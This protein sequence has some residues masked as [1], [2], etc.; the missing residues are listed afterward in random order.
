MIQNL[1][2]TLRTQSRSESMII[3]LK[4]I[5]AFDTSSEES[6]RTIFEA[7]GVKLC[8]SVDTG[9]GVLVLCCCRDP[10]DCLSPVLVWSL[11]LLLSKVFWSGR[12]SDSFQ[13]QRRGSWIPGKER[14]EKVL[15]D[16]IS[17][18]GRKKWICKCCSE[19]NVWTRWRC[20]RC[21]TN[22]P[23]GLRVTYQQAVAARTGEWS[24][25]SSTSSGEEDRKSKARRQR[26]GSFWQKLSIVR[27]SGHVE[28]RADI[29]ETNRVVRLAKAHTDLAL[30]VCRIPV[31]QF[32]LSYGDASGG[33]IPAEQAEAGYGETICRQCL[34]SGGH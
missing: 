16:A 17:I 33:D 34:C 30:F 20:R 29:Q 28:P 18:D 13:T 31:D 9:L 6:K 3:D 14:A 22:T 7:S 5:G 12:S 4:K 11:P 21:Y 1:A 32:F 26:L 2:H 10:G 25:G 27:A 19:S 23:A 24:T 8:V 15:A